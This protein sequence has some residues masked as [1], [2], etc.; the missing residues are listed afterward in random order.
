[1]R[2]DVRYRSGYQR[3]ILWLGFASVLATSGCSIDKFVIGRTGHILEYGL[4]SIHEETDLVFAED[5]LAGNLKMMEALVKGDPENARLL[6]MA[7]EGFTSYALGFVEDQDAAR[8]SQFYLRARNYGLR[9]LRTQSRIAAGLDGTLGD[10]RTALGSANRDM[11]FFAAP[12]RT[13]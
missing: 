6:T 13:Y 11:A 4:A 1:M 5:A 3:F 2:M 7:A 9:A 10:L 8:A 12:P